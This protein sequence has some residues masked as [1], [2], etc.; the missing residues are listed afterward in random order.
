MEAGQ[1]AKLVAD[2][3]VLCI[4]VGIRACGLTV[5]TDIEGRIKPASTSVAEGDVPSRI[6]STARHVCANQGSKDDLE[7]PDGEL[8]LWQH[9]AQEPLHQL[10]DPCQS[11]DLHHA[12]DLGDAHVDAG[13]VTLDNDHP[14]DHCQCHVR[15]EGP[16][17]IVATDINLSHLELTADEVAYLK[18]EEERA[19]PIH[20]GEHG[21]VEHPTIHLQVPSQCVWRD[22]QV[23][24]ES[25]Q[26]NHLKH[27]HLP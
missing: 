17:Q 7:E 22:Q 24:G 20:C 10:H 4:A 13:P 8:V 6:P 14:I 18:L 27:D 16:F 21:E 9:L 5:A 2:L 19:G 25:C 3:V 11:E 12:E 26:P 1:V 23:V 15:N